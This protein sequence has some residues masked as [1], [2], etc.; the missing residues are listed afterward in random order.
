MISL[1]SGFLMYNDAAH[2]IFPRRKNI[3]ALVADNN[4]THNMG[5]RLDNA[6]RKY[7]HAL[8][9]HSQEKIPKN[10]P[11]E[12]LE[13]IPGKEAQAHSES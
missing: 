1:P 8:T 7:R 11:R 9:H 13:Q 3:L 6:I 10:L 2:H 4:H 12:L 5:E